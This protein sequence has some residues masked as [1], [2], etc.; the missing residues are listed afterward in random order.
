MIFAAIAAFMLYAGATGVYWGIVIGDILG[1]IFAYIYCR[2]Y[3]KRLYKLGIF[4]Q[5]PNDSK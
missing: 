4:K 1:S 3:I 5:K 2:Y